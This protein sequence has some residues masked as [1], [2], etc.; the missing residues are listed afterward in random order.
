M[1][2]FLFAISTII[3]M[4]SSS[5]S[6]CESVTNSSDAVCESAINAPMKLSEILDILEIEG[7]SIKIN[8]PY[9]GLLDDM[10]LKQENE[11]TADCK[12]V[13]TFF[14]KNLVSNTF[15]FVFSDLCNE[16]FKYNDVLNDNEIQ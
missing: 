1:K 10:I 4:S 16:V 8:H 14:A 13:E 3:V 9:F 6:I 11:S 12:S 5:T 7:K 15:S 2:S